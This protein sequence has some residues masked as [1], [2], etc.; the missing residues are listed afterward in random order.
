MTAAL[1]LRRLAVVAAVGFLGWSAV[2]VPGPASAE[3]GDVR[4]IG[5]QGDDAVCKGNGE[6]I[7]DGTAP[8]GAARLNHRSFAN[9]RSIAVD[10]GGQNVF[11]PDRGVIR[12][13][14]GHVAGVAV[15]P[16]TIPPTTLPEAERPLT[17]EAAEGADPKRVALDAVG[18]AVDALGQSLYILERKSVRQVNLKGTPA[19]QTIA[20]H[21]EGADIVT[22]QSVIAA[23]KNGNVFV[24][25][26]GTGAISRVDRA[27]KTLTPLATASSPSLAIDAGGT[28]LYASDS[29]TV[30]RINPVTGAKTVVAGGGSV[31]QDG[32]AATS[33]SLSEPLAVAVDPL[34]NHLYIS[35]GGHNRIRKVDL[36]TGVINSVVGS[37]QNG[38]QAT[39]KAESLLLDRPTALAVDLVGNVYI[40]AADE[41]AVLFAERPAVIF[42]P[43]PASNPPGPQPPPTTPAGPTGQD[44]TNTGGQPA[45]ET[46]GT[47]NQ[48]AAPQQGA[49]PVNQT[50]APAGDIG[51][52][53]AQPQTEMR[54][55]DPGNAVTAPEQ[56][57]QSIVEPVPSPGTAAQFTPTP[58]QTPTV[59]QAPTVVQA[60]TPEAGT[61]TVGDPGTSSA[62]VSADAAPAV[63]AAPAVAPVPPAPGSA[64]PPAAQQ[65]VSNVGLAHGDSAVSGRGA[66]RYAMV[67]NDE[68]QSLA[69]ALAMAGA[70]A[71]VAVFLCVMIVAPGAASKPKPRPKGAY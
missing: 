41:C 27:T 45:P 68:E 34:G 46:V 38:F 61:V 26:S 22:Q 64:P 58:V 39:G 32:I 36:A 44:S 17:G 3:D 4:L 51:S 28:A 60:P 9:N 18:V 65:P 16:F 25:N 11:V 31:N 37:G 49:A 21:P 43:P 71:V 8:L 53:A 14:H 35:D 5:G 67:R 66:T 29:T 59:L 6:G 50:Q 1:L 13:L 52:G 19:I 69:A 30:Q 33:V 24:G 47:P 54:V 56:A 12:G 40:L 7:D 57:G 42:T 23:D 48:G 2:V 15:R 20:R 63:P 10:A 55:L 62:G 70:S